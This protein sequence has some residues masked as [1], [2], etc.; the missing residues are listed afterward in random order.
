M[1]NKKVR[2]KYKSVRPLLSSPILDEEVPTP[3]ENTSASRPTMTRARD[4]EA[5]KNEEPASRK[6]PF[7][8]LGLYMAETKRVTTRWAHQPL[9]RRL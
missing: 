7:E 8:G 5:N 3:M 2:K 4:A 1:K 6:R 9:I